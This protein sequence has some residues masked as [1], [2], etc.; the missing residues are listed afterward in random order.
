ME[1]KAESLSF[2]L[3]VENSSFKTQNLRWVI[4]SMFLILAIRPQ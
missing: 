1:V 2:A 3:C 4:R